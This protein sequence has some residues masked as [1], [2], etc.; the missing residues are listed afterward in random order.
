MSEKSP[1]VAKRVVNRIFP[2]MPDFYNLMNDQCDILVTTMEAFTSYMR[3]GDPELGKQIA[4]VLEK[5]GDELKRRNMSILNQ[6]FATPMDREEI[7]RAIEGIDHV[8]NYA[9]TT[10]REMELLGVAPDSNTLEMAQHLQEGALALQSGFRKI[11]SAP[12]D[13]E[14]DA[15]AA[16]KAERRV[17]KCYRKA[18][19]ELFEAEA[20]HAALQEKDG[21]NGSDILRCV[22]E[23][24]KRREIYRHMSDG[25]DR[26]AHAGQTLHDIIVKI[27]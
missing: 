23:I 2:R 20:Q 3:S 9:K 11:S 21:V 27:A 24:L 10:V 25:A 19:S 5:E 6:A 13:A 26:L 16:R 8:I 12:T 15:G 14:E 22:T 7:Y 1:T 17:E 4:S 18:V